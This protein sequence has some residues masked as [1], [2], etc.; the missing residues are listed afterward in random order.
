[1]TT[2]EIEELREELRELLAAEL[3]GS[4][5]DYRAEEYLRDRDGDRGEAVPDGG[6]S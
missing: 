5:D 3:G 1:M 4:P 6:D 2:A